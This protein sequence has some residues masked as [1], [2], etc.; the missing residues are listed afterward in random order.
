MCASPPFVHKYNIITMDAKMSVYTN[1]H[2]LMYN[3]IWKISNVHVIMILFSNYIYVYV[4]NDD[5][6]M[7]FLSSSLLY[8]KPNRKTHLDFSE[9]PINL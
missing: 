9:R 3:I 4:T 6:L 8:Y 5:V 1:L 2:N 7:L